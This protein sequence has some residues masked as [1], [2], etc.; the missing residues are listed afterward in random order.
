MDRLEQMLD[1]LILA[2]VVFVVFESPEL[3]MAYAGVRRRR[4]LAGVCWM[5]ESGLM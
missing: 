1:M 5:S 3:N 4:V 2:F